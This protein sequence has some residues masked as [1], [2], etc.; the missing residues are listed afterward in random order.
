MKPSSASARITTV[1]ALAALPAVVHGTADL[2][3]HGASVNG[4]NCLEVSATASVV[5]SAY[6]S[7]ADSQLFNLVD[8]RTIQVGTQCLQY[9]S[10]NS[11]TAAACVA[12]A[13][14]QQWR[15][16]YDG[17]VVTVGA[18][19]FGRCLTAN[20]V[21]NGAL[22]VQTCQSGLATQVFKSSSL[23]MEPGDALV[24]NSGVCLD[25]GGSTTAVPFQC[26]G[27]TNQV[28][29]HTFDDELRVADGSCLEYDETGLTAV[30]VGACSKASKQKWTLDTTSSTITPTGR[31]TLCLDVYT[32]PVS[33]TSCRNPPSSTQTYNVNALLAARD[34][35]LKRTMIQAPYVVAGTNCVTVNRANQDA[36][37]SPCSAN[38]D[39]WWEVTSSNNIKLQ[40][41][42]CL[43]L[44]GTDTVIYSKCIASTSQQWNWNT[45]T[46]AVVSV[47]QPSKC[48]AF[49]TAGANFQAFKFSAQTCS[50]S[51]LN[52]VLKPRDFSDV[53]PPSRTTLQQ[54]YCS[55][56]AQHVGDL[57]F[58]RDT[59]LW[60]KK[61]VKALVPSTLSGR[62][63][64]N[65]YTSVVLESLSTI[66]NEQASKLSEQDLA[67]KVAA[68]TNGA[69]AMLELGELMCVM[70][71]R[72]AELKSK[73]TDLF[74]VYK[75]DNKR[76]ATVVSYLRMANLQL[77]ASV[78]STTSPLLTITSDSVA[79]SITSVFQGY[80]TASNFVALNDFV[81]SSDILWF[82][83][84]VQSLCTTKP[85][86]SVCSV[87][88]FTE[89][90]NARNALNTEIDTAR[91]NSL[92]TNEVIT[93]DA[94]LKADTFI[95][96]YRKGLTKG[97][98]LDASAWNTFVSFTIFGSVKPATKYRVIDMISTVSNTT[99]MM[100]L[101]LWPYFTAQELGSGSTWGPFY[102][103]LDTAL[104]NARYQEILTLVHTTRV[105]SVE[106][107]FGGVT[108]DMATL[109]TQVFPRVC[110]RFPTYGVCKLIKYHD[111]TNARAAL[112]RR[113]KT[114]GGINDEIIDL[115]KT[116]ADAYAAG[117]AMNDDLWNMTGVRLLFDFVELQIYPEASLL[118]TANADRYLVAYAA[119]TQYSSTMD[120]LLPYFS[121]VNDQVTLAHFN[122]ITA[123]VGSRDIPGMTVYVDPL[124]NTTVSDLGVL[125]TNVLPYLCNNPNNPDFAVCKLQE[126]YFGLRQVISFE[127][128]RKSRTVSLVDVTDVDVRKQLEVAVQNKD[129]YEIISSIQDSA[130]Q[131][132]KKIDETSAALSKSIAE[133]FAA[134]RA[135]I[136]K[137]TAD[138]TKTIGQEAETTRLQIRAS[139]ESLENTIG[140][141]ASAIRNDIQESTRTLYSK[142]DDDSRA[143]QKQIDQSTKLLST[144][145]GD[146]AQKTRASI[147]ASTKLLYTK[148]GDEGQAI[149]TKIDQSTEKL[150]NKIGDEA[151]SI[152]SEIV[153]STDKLFNKIGDEA[154]SIRGKIDQSTATITGEIN[155]STQLLSGKIDAS[156]TTIVN[157]MKTGF[158]AIANYFKA[159]ANANLQTLQ[160]LINDSG[161]ATEEAINGIAEKINAFC[162]SVNEAVSLASQAS[163]A[164]SV[165]GVLQAVTLG[166]QAVLETAKCFN[167]FAWLSGGADPFAAAQ[168]AQDAAKATAA[169]VVNDAK[170]EQLKKK[171][172]AFV[173]QIQSL[174]KITE[175]FKT[176][177][178]ALGNINEL[179]TALSKPDLTE[180][181]SKKLT[182]AVLN[183]YSKVEGATS[184][185]ELEVLGERISS[186]LAYME[187]FV[188]GL[189]IGVGPQTI[190][191]IQDAQEQAQPIISAL[192]EAYGETGAMFENLGKAARAA[193]NTQSANQMSSAVATIGGKRL[194]SL[195]SSATVDAFRPLYSMA[196]A[197]LTKLFMDYKIQAAALAFCNY[198][199]FRLGG[200][201]PAICGKSK[202][203][204]EEDI[205][206]MLA[207][208]TA[209]PTSTSMIAL[210]PTR[211]VAGGGDPNRPRPYLNLEK[212]LRGETVAFALPLTDLAWLKK[213][214]WL[215]FSDTASSVGGM[216]V[217]SM[218]IVLPFTS[219]NSSSPSTEQF[220]V[221]V[222]VDMGQTQLLNPAGAKTFVLPSTTIKFS[223]S[224]NR[225][226]CANSITN[227]YH[228]AANCVK[229]DGSSKLC[230]LTDGSVA[231]TNLL[232]SLFSTWQISMPSVSAT[233]GY[234][235]ALPSLNAST[236]VDL[237]VVVL[238]KVVRIESS[239]STI[240]SA[241]DTKE[242]ATI[243]AEP[244]CCASSEYSLAGTCKA[245][246]IGSTGALN[247][248]SCQRV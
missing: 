37:I 161:D 143:L 187:S 172:E 155:K 58:L 156:T 197:G 203:Y 186:L 51:A 49:A 138:L 204:T 128:T 241:L 119:F 168:L 64:Y 33:L 16:K 18:D 31:P 230:L 248:Y 103:E 43:T 81:L 118:T 226:L 88:Y 234:K 9:N 169:V 137:Q 91:V 106:A 174:L 62:E 199:E 17:T 36:Y 15:A 244:V 235:L 35:N 240:K 127:V 182:D 42:L 96:T 233:S 97:M 30:T 10:D 6:C 98:P 214:D 113:L 69:S 126:F 101:A 95:K 180:Q 112:Q 218:K 109:A 56:R 188:D 159:D 89:L 178:A 185:T 227:P 44:S 152:R 175:Q 78:L 19:K 176:L 194:R 242:S 46:G 224:I 70:R 22:S 38:V 148:I 120:N 11:V 167:P 94:L 191:A 102:T 163:T 165:A 166:A 198:H 100:Q 153:K 122:A 83:N 86:L 53:L 66:I 123:L 210:L 195:Q 41:E 85:G 141:A 32:Y 149:R 65:Y 92:R 27:S 202:Y 151:N 154:N 171:A 40:G 245:C 73:V 61:D 111:L 25:F 132:G 108:S 201:A 3:Q 221:A 114:L 47:A 238:L 247:G 79:K 246:P 93:I 162:N 193:V 2:L 26:H 24:A 213:Y 243:S 74:T 71:D 228:D 208:Q 34:R 190:G 4:D 217:E 157:G 121:F 117:R 170:A 75:A 107:Y 215:L 196:Y 142:M 239:G 212:L 116:F 77:Q 160:K 45:A 68:A 7:G 1:L 14:N 105:Q 237:D 177:Q 63:E 231:R 23:T 211:P 131:I 225:R 130:N 134:T 52:Q 135:D 13:W 222:N 220:D 181:E 129:Q 179:I 144:Q 99:L 133:G 184:S 158:G 90:V 115:S 60:S 28:W 76:L 192:M 59:L 209:P 219:T 140:A 5:V 125:G 139:T 136:A 223:S 207:F 173:G 67:T 8:K 236:A 39:M 104:Y 72:N 80:L 87:T 147:D 82:A 146:E 145:I 50:S 21:I 183:M 48:L 200:V 164:N 54:S 55:Q 57:Q 20:A 29:S 150:Y 216:Y 189:E 110:A 206:K 229:S 84:A 232:P 124:S 12:G 205:D